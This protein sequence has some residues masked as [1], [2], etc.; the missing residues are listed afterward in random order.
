M[1][2]YRDAPDGKTQVQSKQDELYRLI[3]DRRAGLGAVLAL[4]WKGLSEP[5]AKAYKLLPWWVVLCAAAVIVL[6]TLIIARSM[7]SDVAAP[8]RN[9]LATRGLEVSYQPVPAPVVPSRLKTLL[10]PEERAGDLTVEEFGKRTI[11]TLQ[12]PELFQSGSARVSPGHDALFQAIGRALEAVPGRIMIIGHT[13]DQALRSFKYADNIELSRAR[14]VAVAQLI[15]PSISNPSRIEWSGVGSTQ[16]RF[17][18]PSVPENRARNRRVE[19][20]HF[21]E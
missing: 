19:I 15:Q 5:K 14:A 16:P 21:S 7:L 6:G 1:G 13:D 4:H 17:L 10:A 8:T 12:T 11:V 18:P 2:M 9:L 3:R 20:E